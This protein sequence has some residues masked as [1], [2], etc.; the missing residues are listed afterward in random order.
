MVQLGGSGTAPPPPEPAVTI[1][2]NPLTFAT[3][4]QGTASSPMTI[5]VTNSGN[6]TL[7]IT[8]V[9]PGG[10]NPGD[11]N[12]NSTCSGPYAANTGCGIAVTF[13]PLA[14]GQRSATITITD[15]APNSPQIIQVNGTAKSGQPTTPLVTLSAQSLGLGTVTQGTSSAPQNVTV[16][17]SG[18]AP[19]HIS[20]LSLGG[21]SPSDYSLTNG[22]TASPYAVNAACTLNVTFAPLATGTRAAT[23]TIADDAPNSP[24]V[25]T[26]T[27]IANAA[28]SVG[29]A[30]G[31]STSVSVSA[32]QT[33]QCSLQITPGAGYSGT[34]SLAC[35][36]APP[37]ATCPLPASVQVTNGNP[38]TFT[39]SVSTTGSNSGIALPLSPQRDTPTLPT[40]LADLQ[41]GIVLVLLLLLTPSANRSAAWPVQKL[42]PRFVLVFVAKALCTAGCGGGAAVQQVAPPPP[43]ITPSG[44]F[45]LTITPTASSASGKPLQLPAIQL[46]LTVN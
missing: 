11:F 1:N 35:T 8:S 21:A 41:F 15:D 9:T 16:S 37:A 25:I 13:T 43:Q 31:G 22:C 30:A 29:A 40:T 32:G 18:G 17:N 3:I 42:A 19:L 33:A 10:N 46:T 12:V 6:A 36:G 45:S 4:T 20:S 26:L 5:A 14:A 34:V 2:P 23:I 24:Q 38:A 7:Y 39:V 44:N 27:G 28:V